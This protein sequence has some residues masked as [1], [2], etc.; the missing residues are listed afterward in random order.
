MVFSGVT[1]AR[2]DGYVLAGVDF[3]QKLTPASTKPTP[4]G[5]KK[6]Q[7]ENNPNETCRRILCNPIIF[8]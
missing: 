4:A 7:Q 1:P 8:S 5:G 6:H 3:P 2:S